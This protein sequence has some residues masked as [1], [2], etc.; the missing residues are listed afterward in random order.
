MFSH[1]LGIESAIEKPAFQKGT[2]IGR[3][4]NLYY[5]NKIK[6]KQ[7]IPKV[8]YN[9]L[10]WVQLIQDELKWSQDEAF[11]LY[12]VLVGYQQTYKNEDWTPIAIEHGFSK[13]LYEDDENLFVYEGRVDLVARDSK[14]QLLIIDHKTQSMTYSIY[15][16]NNQIIGYLWATDAT[17]FVYNYLVLTKEPQFRRAPHPFSPAQISAWKES[18]VKWFLRIKAAIQSAEFV[19]SLQ[20]ETKFGKCQFTTICEQPNEKI[21]QFIVGSN[22]KARKK[23]RSW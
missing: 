11:K 13:L 8:L 22:Y 23:Y 4:L 3:W 14:G 12:R 10:I 19:P 5:H 21:K 15:P 20:C 2:I 1:L 9:P 17:E 18:T 6:P 7:S 16:F